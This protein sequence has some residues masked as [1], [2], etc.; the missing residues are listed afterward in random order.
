MASSS[1]SGWNKRKFADGPAS[2]AGGQ[3]AAAAVAAAAPAPP[4]LA[5][6]QDERNLG[7]QLLAKMGWKSGTG[8]GSSEQGR[9]EPVLV[10]QFEARAGLGASKGVEAGRY[11]GK[12]GHKRRAL[13]MVSAI[14]ACRQLRESAWVRR[15]AW[16]THLGGTAIPQ[17]EIGS[18]HLVCHE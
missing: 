8:L 1:S 3:P 18:T 10:Q 15:V 5:P 17:F 6:G 16:L 9:V 2:S 14:P 12:E 13:D 11:D 7:N 4:V